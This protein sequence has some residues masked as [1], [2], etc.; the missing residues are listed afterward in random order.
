MLHV[1]CDMLHVTYAEL[2]VNISDNVTGQFLNVTVNVT[3][4]MLHITF[5]AHFMYSMCNISLRI[6][7]IRFP[8]CLT[9]Q[10]CFRHT[11]LELQLQ[12]EAIRQRALYSI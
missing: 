12:V 11:V 1:T 5:T 2:Y 6:S 4:N 9:W 8:R 10:E 7:V 3:C